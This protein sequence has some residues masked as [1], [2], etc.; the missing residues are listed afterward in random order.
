MGFGLAVYAD[1]G[2]Y[3]DM[4]IDESL[5]PDQLRKLHTKLD[6]NGDG[7]ASSAE[8]LDYANNMGVQIAKKDIGS[9]LEEIDMDKDGALSFE[10]HMKDIDSQADGADDEELRELAQRKDLEA[11]KF[12]AADDNGDGKL[13]SHE[14]PGLFYPET[15]EKVLEITVRETL[16]QKDL[17]KDGRLSPR[18]FWEADELEGDDVDL[19]DEEI[20]DFKMLDTNSDGFLNLDELRLWES[21]QFHTGQA[22]KKMFEIADKDGD[23]HITAD[24]LAAT[25]EALAGS[26]AQYHLI[27]WAEHHEL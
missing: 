19:A 22:M 4:D 5:T 12:K 10:E 9:I 8:V 18:E 17:D 25:R 20:E 1:K 7:R 3:D 21:G 26:D 13:H 15:H 11:E 2:S 14:L 27:E 16:G 24:E 6:L 23:G